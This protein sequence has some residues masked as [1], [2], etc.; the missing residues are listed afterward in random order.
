LA[1]KKIPS[2]AAYRKTT[3]TIVNDR[4]AIVE[5]EPDIQKM[6]EKIGMGQIE[7]VIDQAQNELQTAR[8]MVEYRI[9][10][11]LV[12]EPPEDQYRWPIR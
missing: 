11:S 6:E 12:E 8:L 3:E 1:L 4:L 10:E 9:W 5:N 2:E 7:E